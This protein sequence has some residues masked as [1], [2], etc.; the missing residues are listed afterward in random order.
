MNLR[1]NG[2]SSTKKAKTKIKPLFIGFGKQALEYARVMDYYNISIEGVCVRNLN[3]DQKKINR[4][5]IKNCYIDIEKALNDKKFNCVF[6]FLPWNIIEKKISKIIKSTKKPIFVEKPVALSSKKLNQICKLSKKFNKKI[7]VLYNR[8][9]FQSVQFLKNKM[10]NKKLLFQV[11]IPEKKNF[12]IQN[13]DKRL[14]KNIRFHLTSHWIDF[15]YFLFNKKILSFQK[16]NNQYFFY[17]SKNRKIN[18]IRLE[19]DV[20]GFIE[21]KIKIDKKKYYFNKLEYLYEF[22]NNK[23]KLLINENR[24]NQFKP[25]IKKLIYSIK[26]G[27]KLIIPRIYQLRRLYFFLEKLPY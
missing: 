7:Y 27:K 10:K 16:K 22:K 24:L 18:Y 5:K 17:F 3:K 1:K 13:F 21:S 6:V 12:L 15:F 4:Y 25:G 14:K 20:S 8:R 23:Q 26:N 11:F 9:Y 19:Y 2:V